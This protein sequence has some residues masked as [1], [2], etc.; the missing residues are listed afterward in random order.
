MFGQTAPTSN[1]G[2]QSVRSRLTRGGIFVGASMQPFSAKYVEADAQNYVVDKYAA[3]TQ[4]NYGT[5]GKVYAYD[6]GYVLDY[7]TTP[8]NITTNIL[9][10]EVVDGV[11]K[12][13][14]TG[15]E[16]TAWTVELD[17]YQGGY[18]SLY[19]NGNDQGGFKSFRITEL[20]ASDITVT[21]GVTIHAAGD[22]TVVELTDNMAKGILKTN[23]VT[24]ALN[25]DSAKFEY[26]AAVFA[27]ASAE[28]NEGA[29]PAADAGKLGFTVKACNAD[30]VVK[31]FFKNLTDEYD[32]TGFAL[33]IE[34][35]T[36]ENGDA[37][38]VEIAPETVAGDLTGDVKDTADKKLDIRD[39]VNADAN[40]KDTAI[41]QSGLLGINAYA[42]EA[43]AVAGQKKN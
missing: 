32:Y 35:I 30:V 18:V 22:Y 15:F 21:T 27:D 26:R 43:E 10:V 36:K 31:L 29:A 11:A 23:T 19:S 24:G 6:K 3:G 13:W 20:A 38:A 14:W 25:F 9:N 41:V 28:Q 42:A 16:K 1:S 33:E 39:L 4:F 12:V 2:V 7:P 8:D 17:G 5:D 37:L 40:D 34:S